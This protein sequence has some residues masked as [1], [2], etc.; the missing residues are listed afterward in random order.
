[1]AKWMVAKGARHLVLVS[2]SGSATGKVKELIE[3]LGAVGTKVVVRKC[4]VADSASVEKLV[5][6]ELAQMPEVRGVIHG[7]MVLHVRASQL[8]EKLANMSRT[9]CLRE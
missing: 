2:R 8:F 7:A 1:M 6:C 5:G 4:D 9:Y 3:S